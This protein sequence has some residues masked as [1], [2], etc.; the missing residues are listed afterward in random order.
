ME[1]AKEK[2]WIDVHPAL[3]VV[4]DIAYLGMKTH[5]G[6]GVKDV[7]VRDDRVVIDCQLHNLINQNITL[8]PP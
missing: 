4:H 3:D 6:A 1:L 2:Q 8:Q 5:T 7:L